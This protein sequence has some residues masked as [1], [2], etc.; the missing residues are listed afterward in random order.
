LEKV[1]PIGSGIKDKGAMKMNLNFLEY[2]DWM[3]DAL[4]AQSDPSV[5]FSEKIGGSLKLA[6]MVCQM[7]KVKNEC[8]AYGMKG[9]NRYGVWGGKSPR[10]RL[11]LLAKK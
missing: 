2:F 11:N 1:R 4:C 7:C 9:S 8:L 3:D 5:F 10:E 6:K